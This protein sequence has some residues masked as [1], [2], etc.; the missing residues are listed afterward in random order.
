MEYVR[1][2]KEALKFRPDIMIHLDGS[3]IFN[4]C[5]FLC[6]SPAEAVK[7]FDSVTL[8]L[9]KGLSAPVG[10][11][12]VASSD[13]IAVAKKVLKGL[14][15]AMRQGGV[16]AAPGLIAL[17]KMS[18]RLHIDHDNAIVF[19]KGIDSLRQ[20]GLPISCEVDTVETNFVMVHCRGSAEEVVRALAD[21]DGDS[22]GVCVKVNNLQD[23]IRVVFHRH[24]TAQDTQIALK[25]F[26][27]VVEY[28]HATRVNGAHP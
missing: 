17:Q 1:Q 18:K 6:I 24:I 28:L 14:G 26:E 22:T 23:V 7:D 4:A 15:G 21:I 27:T 8:C 19:A 16:L 9:S 13:F 10:S 11:V 20:K 3:R 5:T 25:K 12:L 2:V